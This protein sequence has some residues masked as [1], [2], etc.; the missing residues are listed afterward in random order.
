M[1]GFHHTIEERL[2]DVPVKIIMNLLT[3]VCAMLII[4]VIIWGFWT[5]GFGD[6]LRVLV[7]IYL[8]V[9]VL[10]VV[11][12]SFPVTK[13]RSL[14]LH[15]FM[16][17]SSYNG[18]GAFLLLTGLLTCGI[19][20]FGIF[21]GIAN[22]L[23]GILH[24]CLWLF[25]RDIVTDRVKD[26][27]VGTDDK[28][29]IN[30]GPAE[31]FVGARQENPSYSEFPNYGGGTYGTAGNVAP[32]EY[33]AAQPYNNENLVVADKPPTSGPQYDSRQFYEEE[34]EEDPQPHKYAAI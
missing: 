15:W 7:C 29:F 1:S 13:L 25:F 10:V 27:T 8:F 30:P 32:A 21:V 24:I 18:K 22:M 6:A 19:N 3:I 20:L 31:D 23:L 16:F 26:I 4:V 9:G 28:E 12:A 33:R 2:R 34:D 11:L 5:D 17:L 14:F